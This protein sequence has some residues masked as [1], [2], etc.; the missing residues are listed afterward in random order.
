MKSGKRIIGWALACCPTFTLA[1]EWNGPQETWGLMMQVQGISPMPTPPPGVPKGV[2]NELRRREVS[3][4][5]E[6][7]GYIGSSLG[8]V[9]SCSTGTR[10]VYLGTAVGC[11][12]DQNLATCADLYTSCVDTASDCDAACSA[13]AKILKCPRVEQRQYCGRY[14]FSSDYT[15]YQCVSGGSVYT[16]VQLVADYYATVASGDLL[17][18]ASG[19]QLGSGLSFGSGMQGMFGQGQATATGSSASATRTRSG[20]ATGTTGGTS[21][22]QTSSSKGQVSISTR[23]IGIIAGVAA[24]V[25]ILIIAG[26]FIF[27]CRR[28]KARKQGGKPGHADQPLMHQPPPPPPNTYGPSELHNISNP[29]LFP[30]PHPPHGGPTFPPPPQ[31]TASAGGFYTDPKIPAAEIDGR[32]SSHGGGGNHMLDPHHRADTVSPV[33]T[34]TSPMYGGGGQQYPPPPLQ[35]PRPQGRYH[36]QVYEMGPSGR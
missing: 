9:L 23:T 30:P 1:A 13:D 24:V 12:N 25:I 6:I 10:C 29:N 8:Q 14:A 19:V 20:T 32:R 36:P 4:P 28:R 16:G 18:G 22:A 7:C 21:A 35:H 3:I 2:P 27:F 5:T 33:S 17:G 26:V 11:C 15:K 31:Y 34:A